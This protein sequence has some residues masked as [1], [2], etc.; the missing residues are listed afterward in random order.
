MLAQPAMMFGQS[1]LAIQLAGETFVKQLRLQVGELMVLA[2]AMGN[3]DSQSDFDT[4]QRI[5]DEQ[6]QF[7]VEYIKGSFA[8]EGEIL[9]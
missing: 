6:S 1:C 2:Q 4:L 3:V 7:L 8:G 9:R 5:Q